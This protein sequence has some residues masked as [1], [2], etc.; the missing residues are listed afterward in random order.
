MTKLTNYKEIILLANNLQKDTKNFRKNLLTLNKLI[1]TSLEEIKDDL[2]LLDDETDH[3]LF[4]TNIV[5]EKLLKEQEKWT[6]SYLNDRKNII[7]NLISK[8]KWYAYEDVKDG[9]S[10]Q[11]TER[12]QRKLFSDC[13]ALR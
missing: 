7:E 4:S 9:K 5:S 10:K 2:T 11:P 3:L 1:P 12:I 6:L 13:I 8:M